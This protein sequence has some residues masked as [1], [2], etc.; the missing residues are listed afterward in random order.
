M[1]RGLIG[2]AASLSFIVGSSASALAQGTQQAPQPVT[3]T[4][5]DPNEVVCEKEHDTSSRLIINR[6]C[7]TRGQWAEQRRS[8]VL[9]FFAVGKV[10]AGFL[11]QGKE[12]TVSR[13]WGPERIATG[14]WRRGTCHAWRR[15]G[16]SRAWASFGR[17][18]FGRGFATDP[19]RSAAL[20]R[21]KPL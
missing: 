11:W 20:M 14:W 12:Y 3:K 8:E 5:H 17:L 13:W 10:P 16:W 4:A 2:V 6:V 18:P 9:A 21:R 1:G 7:M 19:M 15:W